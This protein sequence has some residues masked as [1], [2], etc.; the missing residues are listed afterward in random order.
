MGSI[1]NTKDLQYQ[2]YI[3]SRTTP[4]DAVRNP[5]FNG[6]EKILVYGSN[7]YEDVLNKLNYFCLRDYHNNCFKCDTE[8]EY[9]YHQLIDFVMEHY[10]LSFGI[11]HDFYEVNDYFNK[12]YKR[13]RT[14]Y[15]ATEK[16]KFSAPGYYDNISGVILKACDDEY[17]SFNGVRNSIWDKNSLIRNFDSIYSNADNI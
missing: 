13:W 4:Y 10:Y 5:L 9:L 8:E 2:Y 6:N 16:Y 11:D 1:I 3:L 14:F 12:T 17:Y 15:N 7:N